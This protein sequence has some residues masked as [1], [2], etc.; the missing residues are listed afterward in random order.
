MVNIRM[1][2]ETMK[3]ILITGASGFI[4]SFLVEEALARG[5]E[6]WAGV[7]A[8]SSRERLQDK[9]IRFID[10]NYK[11]EEALVAQLQEFADRHGAW[12][13][14]V[15]NAGLT[16]TLKKQDFFRVNAEN[17]RALIDAL[18]QAG[19]QP[20]K[21][22]LMSSLSAYGVGDEKDFTPIRLEDP[23]RPNTVYGES[24]RMAEEYVRRQSHFPYVIMRPTGVYGPGDKDYFMEIKSIQSGFDFAVG[25][26]PQRIT[27]IYVKD[28]A[29]AVFLALENPTV[30]N[31]HYFVADGDV[32]T[33]A[34]FANMIRELLSKKHLLRMR[35]PSG[36]VYVACHFSELIGKILGKSMT[37]NSDKYKILKQRNWICEV[38]PLQDE[39]NFKANYRLRDGLTEA[40][41]WY[42]REGWL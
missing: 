31:R 1:K 7:R 39:L 17:T 40:I 34:E 16:K 8:S 27:F 36:L 15:H 35:I 14:V 42:R 41:A 24:K 33:D 25:F 38:E 19:C 9:R 32:Y 20:R 5:Y 11:N 2:S 21:F 23:Q 18:A 37:L 30:V 3:K 13:Y 22:L 12:D 4:G 28:L 6:V 29:R 26:T 10:L